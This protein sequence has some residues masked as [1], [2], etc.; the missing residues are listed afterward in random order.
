MPYPVLRSFS[1]CDVRVKFK[2][3]VNFNCKQIVV[4]KYPKFQ[5]IQITASLLIY[6]KNNNK[7]AKNDKVS[8]IGVWSLLDSQNQIFPRHAV[9]VR[10]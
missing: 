1:T 2:D 7:N 4:E 3:Y 8:K 5:A 10:C 6:T 9:F